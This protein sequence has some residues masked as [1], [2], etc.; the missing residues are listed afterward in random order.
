MDTRISFSTKAESNKAREQAF[1][2]LTPSQRFQAFIK[3]LDEL[4]GFQ[5]QSI[6][7]NTNNNF[8]IE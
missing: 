5:S 8:I 4:K 2:A 6:K 7:L 1:L 3:S